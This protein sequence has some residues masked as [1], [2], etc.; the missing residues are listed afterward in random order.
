MC[1]LAAV[2]NDY[3]PSTV[4]GGPYEMRGEWSLDVQKGGTAKF[5]SG[6]DDG[7]V[8]LRDYGRHAS[9]PDESVD[10]ESPHAPY[11]RD[12]CDGEL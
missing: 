12:E 1:I 4:S 11:Q 3:T 6:H 5:L 8:G 9:G 2:F 10:A 7:N